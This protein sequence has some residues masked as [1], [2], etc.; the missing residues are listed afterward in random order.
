MLRRGYQ[1]PHPAARLVSWQNLPILATVGLAVARR[2]FQGGGAVTISQDFVPKPGS[3]NYDIAQEMQRYV[4][5]QYS[6]VLGDC[7]LE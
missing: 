2:L 4:E 1:T 3:M 7:W 6:P 5:A